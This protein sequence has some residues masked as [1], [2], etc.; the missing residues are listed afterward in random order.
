MPNVLFLSYRW[1]DERLKLHSSDMMIAN[2]FKLR[3]WCVRYHDYRDYTKEHSLRENQ[4]EI[5][6]QIMKI[7]PELIF[8]TKGENIDPSTI[9]RAKK[10][11]FKGKIICW[12]N[13][14]RRKPVRCVLDILKVCDWFFYCAGGE[15][16]KD[17]YQATKTPASFLFAPYDPNYFQEF[18]N[19][20]RD[21]NVS[22]YGQLYK[23][24]RGFDSLRRDIIPKVRD[25]IDDYGACFNR[26][27]IRG[28]EY[29]QRLCQSKM[30]ISIPAIDLPFYFS[31][32]QSHIM[33]CGSVTLS[34]RFKNI[35]DIFSEGTNIISF[36]DEKELRHKI[37]YYLNNREALDEIRKNS[38]SFADRFM[39][40]D[41]VYNEI[42]HVLTTGQS[43]YPFDEVINPDQRKIFDA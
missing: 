30:S 21:I 36:S 9:K 7:D 24:E 28:K 37:S 22:W 40:S 26:T 15:T 18:K 11:G 39:K 41:C 42:M 1:N 4:N 14:I 23:T 12:Y 34:Y 31:N 25:I 6:R 33:G 35:Y 20:N 27:F 32:R 8:I 38:V 10:N 29:Y 17:Y 3:G 43:T 2:A 19:D 16:L 5:Y 13:D